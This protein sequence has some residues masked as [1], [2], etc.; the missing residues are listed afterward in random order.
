[1]ASLAPEVLTTVGSFPITNTVISTLIVDSV[2]IGSVVALNK[3]LK[4][5]PGM[6]QNIFESLIDGLYGFTEQI[7]G[8]NAAKIFPYFMSFFLFILVANWMG[9]LPGVG[10]IGFFH[11]KGEEEF[12]PLLRNATSDLNVTFALAVV[13]L[14][15]THYLSISTIGLKE[16]LSRYFSLNPIFLFVGMLEII[17]EITKMI[18]LSF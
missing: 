8:Q 11:G 1:M 5:I 15:A 4:R 12:V 7:A 14:V 2:I 10:T 9:L 17:S 13:S 16:Y 3:N 6:F 18:S